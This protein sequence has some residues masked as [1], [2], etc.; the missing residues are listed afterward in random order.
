MASRLETESQSFNCPSRLVCLH[1][2]FCLVGWIVWS[3][4][5]SDYF[6]FASYFLLGVSASAS[7]WVLLNP[8]DGILRFIT[9]T[10][11]CAM[12]FIFIAFVF[13][14][15]LQFCDAGIGFG[16]V[17]AAIP[18]G[19]ILAI[20][21]CTCIVLPMVLLGWVPC[22]SSGL[23]LLAPEDPLESQP[24]VTTRTYLIAFV[25]VAFVMA[26]IAKTMQSRGVTAASLVKNTEN[27]LLFARN[28]FIL[29]GTF[30]LTWAFAYVQWA[31]GS[32]KFSGLLR[33]VSAFGLIA[34][35]SA[36][37]MMIAYLL[38]FNDPI[39]G[40]DSVDLKLNEALVS[41]TAGGIAL[42]LSPILVFWTLR[43][44]GFRLCYRGKPI[45]KSM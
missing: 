32:R 8:G 3:Q 28:G 17:V 36:G 42:S 2:V 25:L 33:V 10:F 27:N 5:S 4:L 20:P 24:V 41:S 34:V 35:H 6:A 18:G 7:L 30:Y 40:C 11:L 45:G 29:A 21:F 22:K 14:I 16:F 19:A 44:A 9:A 43:K 38:P 13:G 1:V 31:L 37:W 39:Y 12:L 26:I 23:T 15:Y